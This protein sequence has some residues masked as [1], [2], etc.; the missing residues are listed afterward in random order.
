MKGTVVVTFIAALAVTAGLA[1]PAQAATPKE[2]KLARQVKTLKAQNSTLKNRAKRLTNR[3]KT[4]TTERNALAA[5]KTALGAQVASLT[6]ERDWLS[7]K[8]DYVSGQLT[9]AQ[10]QL[11]TAQQGVVPAIGTM[12]E[13]DLY[14]TVLPAISTVFRG[15]SSRFTYDFYE[16]DGYSSRD[17]GY[18]GFC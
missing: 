17:F 13:A 18:C 6:T 2:R 15:G 7:W 11:T 4:L 9:T 1:A 10:G 14:S 3:N 5:D 16:S 8:V 12:S